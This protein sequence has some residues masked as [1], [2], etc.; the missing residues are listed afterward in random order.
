MASLLL[1]PLD[2]IKPTEF[3]SQYSEWIYFTLLLIFFISVAGI[4][5]RKHFEKAYV[6]PL[7]I[8]VGLMLTVGIFKFKHAL[9]KVFEGWGILGTVLLG[10][11]AATIPFGLSR[12]FGLSGSKS[13]YLTYILF[14]VL[15]WA[16]LPEIY[17]FL[18]DNNLG[19][20]NLALLILFFVAIYKLVKFGGTSLSSGTKL[21]E[22]S[23]L[24]PEIDQEIDLQSNEQKMVRKN[25]EKMTQVE[26]R[27][28]DDIAESLAEI[29]RI[30]DAHRNN[31]PF[32]EW[33]RIARVLKDISKR[34][35]IFKKSIHKIQK[36]FKRM[37]SVDMTQLKEK[38]VRLEKVDGKEKQILKNEIAVD[39]K[40]LILE[41][42]ILGFEERLNQNMNSFINYLVQVIE[43]IKT[44]QY[45]YD[46]KPYLDKA[47]GTLK[48]MSAVL[49]EIKALEDKLAEFMRDEKG[50]LKKEK[51]V[52]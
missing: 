52:I 19:I 21:K 7:I 29:Q 39:E 30:I 13:F 44:S 32:E 42:E 51:E 8:S 9:I 10:I 25:A 47:K 4:T 15:S 37:G 17:Y 23:A 12:G 46:A 18:G 24:E 27:T 26:I 41:K 11:I 48:E 34:E 40:K 1:F 36:T 50:L 20:I 2:Q 35:D 14:Y 45:P 43:H 22:R 38:K 33:E 16:Q 3:L 49:N 5:L 6:K 28:I 31:L